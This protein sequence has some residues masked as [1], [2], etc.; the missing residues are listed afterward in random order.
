MIIE[1]NFDC[2]Y[3]CTYCY[4]KEIPVMNM[5]ND[6]WE[7]IFIELKELKVKRVNI[8]PSGEPFV[9]D[10]MI[11]KL[12]IVNGLKVH[13]YMKTNFSRCTPDIQDK[14]K[15]MEYIHLVISDYG[16][17]DY[18]R[19]NKITN[20]KED[21]WKIL[22]D[23]IKYSK[24]IDMN[25]EYSSVIPE[26]GIITDTGGKCTNSYFPLVRPDGKVYLC[27]SIEGNLVIGDV[28]TQTLKEILISKKRRDMIK[29]LPE[30]CKTCTSMST[31]RKI[32]LEEMR[33]LK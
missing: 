8:T 12:E 5:D 28:N 27:S 20:M 7:T 30:F 21:E 29:N 15:N 25:I 17:E 23:N 9:F 1:P 32:G 13:S 2:N 10:D 31:E 33:L 14:I 22:K 18:G 16:S 6:L 26:E 3:R 19:F 24:E 4:N 11:D